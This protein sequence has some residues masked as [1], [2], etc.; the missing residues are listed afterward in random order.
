MPSSAATAAALISSGPLF[1]TFGLL[2]TPPSL[3]IPTVE[4]DQAATNQGVRDPANGRDR[5]D[6]E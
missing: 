2:E 1:P 6:E 5:E 3:H 4:A